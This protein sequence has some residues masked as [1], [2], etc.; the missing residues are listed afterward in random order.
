MTFAELWRCAVGRCGWVHAAGVWAL[1]IAAPP[2]LSPQIAR[3][4]AAK[5]HE[6]AKVDRANRFNAHFDAIVAAKY[7]E[8]TDLAMEY[9]SEPEGKRVL[10]GFMGEVQACACCV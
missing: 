3:E 7:K 6:Q 10:K 4:R 9:L 2:V 8:I 5:A 1:T